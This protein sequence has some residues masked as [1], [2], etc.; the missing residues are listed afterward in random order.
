MSD[1]FTAEDRAEPVYYGRVRVD[2][3]GNGDHRR[4]RGLRSQFPSLTA[5]IYSNRL[6]FFGLVIFQLILVWRLMS[7]SIVRLG[8][9]GHA[10]VSV[11]RGPERADALHYL[12]RV[13]EELDRHGLFVGRHVWRDEPVTVY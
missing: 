8:V 13:Y 10:D 4:C 11:L 3:A 6:I 1:V 12:R 9:H 7:C 5:A 2:D